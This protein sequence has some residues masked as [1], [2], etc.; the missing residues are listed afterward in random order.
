MQLLAENLKTF[1][2]KEIDHKIGSSIVLLADILSL[3]TEN[4]F[5]VVD[6]STAEFTV[7]VAI[8]TL[9][10]II[11]THDV[12]TDVSYCFYY[13]KYL[14]RSQGSVAYLVLS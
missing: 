4:M 14:A 6:F 3:I 8:S 12:S 1:L 2:D 10:I 5:N 9:K 13:L 11:K 7:K